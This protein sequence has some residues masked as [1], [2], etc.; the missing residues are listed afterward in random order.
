MSEY[1]AGIGILL[2]V[3]SPMIVPVGV[4]I[5][6][7]VGQRRTQRRDSSTVS[8]AVTEAAKQSGSAP[9]TTR[10]DDACSKRASA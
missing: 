8:T 7:W 6:D 3:L 1:L 10:G 9:S 5:A 4:T 2:L